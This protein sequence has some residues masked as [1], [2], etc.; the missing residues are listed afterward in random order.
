MAYRIAA[1]I[2]LVHNLGDVANH[3][4][5]DALANEGQAELRLTAAHC[6]GE[7]STGIYLGVEDERNDIARLRSALAVEGPPGV[8]YEPHVTLVH[9]RTTTAERSSD[10]W[11]KLAGWRLDV[12]VVIRTLVERF[13]DQHAAEAGPD[14]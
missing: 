5:F 12:A 8:N 13:L 7:P 1:H 10:A 14:D 9:S 3:E 11:R 6:W 4:R 2:T